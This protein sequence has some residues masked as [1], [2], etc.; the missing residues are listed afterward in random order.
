MRW[1][2]GPGQGAVIAAGCTDLLAATERPGLTGPVLDVT[3]IH[4]ISGIRQAEDGWRFGA[5]A[6]WTDLIRADL[7]P[8]FDGLKAAAREV[9]SIQ[10]QNAATLGGNLCNASPAADGVPCWLVL[11]AEVELAGPG[12]LRRMPLQT[13][14][15]GPRQTA[16]APGE[17]M[18]AILVPRR[19]GRGTGAFFKLGARKYL[20]ISI[21][22]AAARIELA[23]DG[24]IAHAALSVGACSPVA[25][26]LP[27]VEAALIGQ[28]ASAPVIEEDAVAGLLAPITDIR[29]DAAY[30]R[31]IAPVAVRRAIA[32]AVAR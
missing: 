24:R 8:A 23:E 4:E 9:G 26:R 30:R 21:A 1:L 32:M 17:V 31:E 25:Q 27:E 29:G 28:S 15:T 20:V 11:E 18:T 6:T 5:A 19:A 16:L 3:G 14:L 13:F 7:P 10:I 2:A 22:M 12:G